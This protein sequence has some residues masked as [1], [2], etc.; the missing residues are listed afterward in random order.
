MTL[1]DWGLV[2]FGVV[3]ALDVVGLAVEARRRRRNGQHS[4]PR[5]WGLVVFRAVV[6]ANV[7][8]LAFDGL[9]LLIGWRTYSEWVWRWPWLGLPV[10]LLQFVGA[11][12]LSWHFW[13]WHPG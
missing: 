1:L 4:S 5:R 2:V 11:A 8:G 10:V 6:V 3:V 13:G 12:G 9:L 7:L